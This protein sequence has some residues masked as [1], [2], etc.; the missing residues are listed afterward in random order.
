VCAGYTPI[1]STFRYQALPL[2]QQKHHAR[3]KTAGDRELPGAVTL[4]VATG[5][6][7]HFPGRPILLTRVIDGCDFRSDRFAVRSAEC[8]G[9][10][11]RIADGSAGGVRP[12][13]VMIENAYKH[14]EA[15]NH[16]NPG[17]KPTMIEPTQLGRRRRRG[18][19][20]TFFQ[21]TR[22]H[23]KLRAVSDSA[24]DSLACQSLALILFMSRKCNK[25]K[26]EVSEF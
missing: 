23:V 18:R 3:Q 14:L 11:D 9:Q 10:F 12:P 17:S 26:V 6:N 15:W 25:T 4:P 20:G 13:V 5:R 7:G 19:T 24:P 2:L 21:L 22:H 1:T 16:A 8:T